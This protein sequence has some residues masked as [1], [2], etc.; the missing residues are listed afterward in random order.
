MTWVVALGRR[1]G[2]LC[3]Y[4]FAREYSFAVSQLRFTGVA[5]DVPPRD[6]ARRVFA[7]VG[8]A[9]AEILIQHRIMERHDEL[10]TYQGED[11]IREMLAAKGSAIALGAHLG[12]VELMATHFSRVKLDFAVVTRQPH[13]PAIA[14]L[15]ESHRPLFGMHTSW[16]EKPRAG[17]E[18]INALR[19]GKVVG[20]LIDQDIDLDNRFASFF[21]LEAVSSVSLIKIA[22]KYH[23]PIVSS[24]IVRTAPL[25]HQIISERIEYESLEG[26]LDDFQLIDHVLKIFNDR[27]EKLIVQYPDQW[28][29]WHR[30]WR[31][32][33]GVDYRAHP[34]ALMSS[35]EY[36]VWIEGQRLQRRDR[37]METT[38]SEEH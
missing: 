13:S 33:P 2:Y 34:E 17:V 36:L 9:I 11:Q 8:E 37:D 23:L 29:W 21:G 16:R 35:S 6:F 15:F 27:L 18:L 30:R 12:C 20:A 24:F 7:H 32:R 4:I 14:E 10:F 22:L 28:V 26:Q 25:H 1:I 19:S 5:G 38:D 3:S 31:R